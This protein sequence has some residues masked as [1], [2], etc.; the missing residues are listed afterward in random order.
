MDDDCVDEGITIT[1]REHDQLASSSFPIVSTSSNLYFR[2]RS[3]FP[4]NW[5]AHTSSRPPTPMKTIGRTQPSA[6]VAPDPSIARV[7]PSAW[8]NLSL[9]P[10]HRRDYFRWPLVLDSPRE[11]SR[12]V[13]AHHH[14]NPLVGRIT[15]LGQTLAQHACTGSLVHVWM[16]QVVTAHSYLIAL[17]AINKNFTPQNTSPF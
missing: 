15:H 7:L 12:Y 6:P 4:D 11:P 16:C 2:L 9:P 8:C 13:H 10:P 5:Q 1:G 3:H 17:P 14:T